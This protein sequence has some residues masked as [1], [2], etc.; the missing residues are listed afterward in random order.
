MKNR[1]VFVLVIVLFTIWGKAGYGQDCAIKP[2]PDDLPRAQTVKLKTWADRLQAQCEALNTQILQFKSKCANVVA[3]SVLDGECQTEQTNLQTASGDYQKDLAAYDQ[4]LALAVGGAHTD[5]LNRE[6]F[7]AAR[8]AALRGEVYFIT[9]SGRKIKATPMGAFPLDGG[10]KIV[11]GDNSRIQLL[12]P[13]ETIFTLG[14]N[15]NMVID[16]YVYDPKTSAGKFTATIAKGAFRFVSGHVGKTHGFE[17]KI[18]TAVIAIG[19]R[20]TDFKLFVQPDGSGYIQLRSGLL[21]ITENKTGSMFPLK[22]GQSV[23]FEADGTL[24]SPQALK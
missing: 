22:G 17:K 14:P 10:T 1:T 4:S 20:G 11:S 9:P 8:V 21:E 15:S 19:I 7:P 16:D 3:G 6:S 24:G 5:D 18:L 23:K 13:D 12:L 2:V